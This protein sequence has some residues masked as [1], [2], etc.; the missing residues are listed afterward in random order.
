VVG[1]IIGGIA[2][3]WGGE[4]LGDAVG[5]A[6]SD[7]MDEAEERAAK[8]LEDRESIMEHEG[9]RV[10]YKPSTW[11]GGKKGGAD[12]KPD[13][14]IVT[15]NNLGRVSEKYESGGRG[16]GTVSNGVGDAGG[17]S[18]GKHQLAS[19]TGTMDLF[20][21]SKEAAAYADRFNG[22]KPGTTAFNQ[23]YK[24][25][26]E[27]DPEGFAK[28]QHDFI[29]RSHFDPVAGYA[30]V[31]GLDVNDP[32]IQEALWSQSV[33]HSGKGNKQIID[34]AVARAGQGASTEEVVN[35]LYDARSDYA[36]QYASTAA[37][38]GRYAKERKDVLAIAENKALK[39]SLQTA[40]IDG[41]MQTPDGRTAS[42]MP[43][44]REIAPPQQEAQPQ[45]GGQ[46]ASRAANG[47]RE[48][49]PIRRGE[50]GKT[51]SQIPTEYDDTLLALMAVDRI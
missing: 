3:A 6:V 39:T 36:G 21:N 35:A 48:R 16:V 46:P 18:Y 15:G 2:G 50:A 31:K 24:Q 9:R 32:A 38:T 11:F 42:Q 44:V 33:Q 45:Q 8:M 10:W 22:L 13:P 40:A 14:D 28:A 49:E 25:V 29:K 26:A 34:A 20:L 37:T 43:S 1:A 4:R 30:K 51:E 27:S 17:V 23:A 41:R 5:K 19:K 12:Y 47:S 7:T